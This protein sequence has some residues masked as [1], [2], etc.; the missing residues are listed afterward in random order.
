MRMKRRLTIDPIMRFHPNQKTT[1]IRSSRPCERGA[2]N[3][4]LGSWLFL[5]VVG[6][7]VAGIPAYAVNRNVKITAPA[8]AAAGTEVN[9]SVIAGTDAD[10]GEQIGFFHAEYSTDTGAT[11]TSISYA[12]DEGPTATHSAKFTVGPAGSK[13]IVRVRVAFRGGKASDVDFKGKLI[14]WAGTWTKWSEPPAKSAT[15]GIVAK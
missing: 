14:D 13:T 9:I 2:R 15:I 10:D 4:R 1:A 11:W 6:L 12:R 5:A 8:S 3:L 7:A